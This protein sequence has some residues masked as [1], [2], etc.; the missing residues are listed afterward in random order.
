[1]CYWLYVY[2]IVCKHYTRDPV[3]C[4]DADRTGMRCENWDADDNEIESRTANGTFYTKAESDKCM[5]CRYLANMRRNAAADKKSEGGSGGES[6]R[7]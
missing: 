3:E 5:D 6:L 1:M 4:I 2:H 7:S